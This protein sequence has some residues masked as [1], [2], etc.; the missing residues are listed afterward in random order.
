MRGVNIPA[1]SA[2]CPACKETVTAALVRGSLENLQ[3]DEGDVELA[4]PTDDSRVGDHRWILTDQQA[5][6]RLRKLIGKST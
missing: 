1:F 2:Y 6:A 4:H 5:R 3:K